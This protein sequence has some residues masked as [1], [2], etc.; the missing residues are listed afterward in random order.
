[1][2][3]P[4]ELLDSKSNFEYCSEKSE[5]KDLSEWIDPTINGQSLLQAHL[6]VLLSDS[7]NFIRITT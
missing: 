5:L 4:K 3:S 7:D 6:N 1:M 2:S